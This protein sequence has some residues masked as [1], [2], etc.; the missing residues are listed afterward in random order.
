VVTTPVMLDAFG[1]HEPPFEVAFLWVLRRLGDDA[2][3]V[4]LE[5]S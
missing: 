3:C 1:L 5:L 4:D 2:G